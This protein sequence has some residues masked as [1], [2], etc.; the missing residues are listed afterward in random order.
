[1]LDYIEDL[2]VIGRRELGGQAATG[3]LE[4]LRSEVPD[5]HRA[6]VA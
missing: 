4:E 6:A 2:L 3:L 5:R 1:V